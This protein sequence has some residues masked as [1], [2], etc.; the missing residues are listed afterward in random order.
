MNVN[1]TDKGSPKTCIY[2]YNL[3]LKILLEVEN[4]GQGNNEVELEEDRYSV[5]SLFVVG[6]DV[7][8][9]TANSEWG[10]FLTYMPLVIGS[11]RQ[12]GTQCRAE[13]SAQLSN[14][15]FSHLRKRRPTPLACCCR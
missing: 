12:T 13:Q 15:S 8:D 7:G 9:S 11:H 10:Y 5:G 4:F 2:K 14:C 1:T 6:M 3:F